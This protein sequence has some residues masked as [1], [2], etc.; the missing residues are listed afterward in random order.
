MVSWRAVTGFG[1]VG[2]VSGVGRFAYDPNKIPI[3][4]YHGP[5][6]R[7]ASP[8]T[9]DAN[10]VLRQQYKGSYPL[11][12]PGTPTFV[13]HVNPNISAAADFT[14]EQADF[15]ANPGKWLTATMFLALASDFAAGVIPTPAQIIA[16]SFYSTRATKSMP[17]T[18][19]PVDQYLSAPGW[20]DGSYSYA[21]PD[22]MPTDTKYWVL[23]TPTAV[24]NQTTTPT[25][26]SKT[27]DL[28]LG[29]VN[30]IGRALSVWSNRTPLAP[31][32]TAPSGQVTT[33][34]GSE[35]TLSFSPRDPDRI[36]S[37]PGDAEIPNF[38]DLAGVHVQYAPRPTD[39]NPDPVWSDLPIANG[40]GTAFEN[41]WFID[42]GVAPSTNPT[43]PEKFWQTYNLKI[44]C[45][46]SAMLAPNA[47]Y[48][49]S[50][51]WQIRVRTF[52]YGHYHSNSGAG[53]LPPILVAP[54]T[55][56]AHTYPVA[57]TSPWS[58]PATVFITAQVPPPRALS[59][60]GNIALVEGDPVTLTWQYRNTY[61]P[62][63]PQGAR[64]VQMRK[65][66]DADWTTVN[67]QITD[68]NS[69]TVSGFALVSGNQYSWRVLTQDISGVDSAY[70]DPA[71]F[72]IV[73]APASG[74]VIPEPSDMINGA[75]LG[76]GT[77]RV[78]VFRR[79]GKR[80]VAEITGVSSVEWNRMRDEISDAKIV[81][82]DWDLDCGELLK[83]L[84]SWAYEIVIFRDNGYSVE[85]V[86]EG[87]ITLL[88]YEEDQVVIHA[89]D[90]MVYAYRRIV[91]QRMNDSGD[92][93]TAGRTV[94]QRA[95]AIMQN[96][97]APSDPNILAYM[98]VIMT[99]DD[100][101]QYRSLPAYSRTGYEEIDDM[102][103]N[104][105]LDY[106]AVGRSVLLWSTKHRIGTLPEFTDKDLG[107]SPIVSEYGMSM[108]NRYA[109]S[110]GNGVWGEATR[111]DENGEDPIYGPVEMLSSTWA[112]EAAGEE[113]TYT[114]EGIETV[115]ESF[116]DS[117]ERSI[118]DRYPPPVV[119]R[120]PDNTTLNPDTVIS[121]QHLVPGVV[122]PLRSVSTLRSVK[123]SQKLDSVKVIETEGKETIS[124]T[125]SPFSRDDLVI[126]E[127]E[128]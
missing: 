6:Y 113:G 67:V 111:L 48:L 110:D 86:W 14:Y 100:A 83:S 94:V 87:P 25:A 47:A 124:I 13:Y 118:S 107:N 8:G 9:V 90:V 44:R 55:Y 64:V 58:A 24:T 62:P 29:N 3:A 12:L 85:R 122:V 4:T 52:D 70:S 71:F 37:F 101:K 68:S 105:G 65:V 125:L 10:A 30:V 49:P 89:K 120:V 82:R 42:P 50:G 117:A 17:P 45:G 41:G 31:I 98:Q 84:Q 38:D 93:P 1:A 91:K 36:A 126:G 27:N 92:S 20:I 76:C 66:G 75:T 123:A 99:D 108:A 2:F 121:I 11:S 78:E 127:G 19:A 26:S 69:W 46:T 7:L 116:A 114:Q 80:R 53:Y 128:V 57:N 16:A 115:S 104:A 43:G 63:Y 119:V 35:I 106:T 18:Y 112:S 33:F 5:A 54:G 51:D 102:A 79:G 22:N 39:A 81:V 95:A 40:A 21:T 59:P 72:W 23:I 34:A 61:N 32:I 77:H 97:F 109:V 88:T 96:I 74:A 103:A 60:V 15:D 56:D 28:P 73:P